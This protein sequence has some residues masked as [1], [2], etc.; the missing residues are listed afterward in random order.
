MDALKH[1]PTQAVYLPLWGTNAWA[2]PLME[3]K[4]VLSLR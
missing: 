3:R 1:M 4:M 2:I